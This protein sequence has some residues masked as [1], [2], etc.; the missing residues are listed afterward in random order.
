MKDSVN[1]DRFCKQLDKL[2]KHYGVVVKATIDPK[3]GLPMAIANVLGNPFDSR[4]VRHGS[5]KYDF[6]EKVETEYTHAK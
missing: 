3:D 4:S 6:G 1:L 2:C 5:L